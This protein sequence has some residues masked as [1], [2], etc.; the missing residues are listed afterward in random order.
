MN[1][2]W[3]S[4]ALGNMLWL[5]LAFAC[6]AIFQEAFFLKMPS[7]SADVDAHLALGISIFACALTCDILLSKEEDISLFT[8]ITFFCMLV[9]VVLVL[10][11]QLAQSVT[12]PPIPVMSTLIVFVIAKTISRFFSSDWSYPKFLCTKVM[13]V[14]D[15]KSSKLI[16]AQIDQSRGRFSLESLFSV[17]ER[18]HE[19]TRAEELYT[20]SSEMGT[21]KLYL[22]AQKV[23]IQTI[24]V[25][26]A[27]RRGYMPVQQML[28]CRML[29]INIVEAQTFYEYISRKLYIE[30]LK[31]S[32]FIF[33]SVFSLSLTRRII[34][35]TVDIIG[36]VTGLLLLSPLFP[37]LA[38][39][40]HL[41]SPGPVFFRQV[42]VGL[43][44][45]LFHIIKFRSMRN[46]AEKGT[47]AVWAKESDPRVTRIGAFLRKS[48]LDEIPQLINVL[49]GDMSLV[50][51]RP[52]RPEFIGELKKSIPFYGERHS[53]KPGVTGWAQV[54]YPYGA[55]VEDA[56][57][58][59][60]YD[61]YYIKNQSVL[62]EFEILLRTLLIIFTR[63]GAR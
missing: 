13:I 11:S 8:F 32:D 57:E 40:I 26:F 37:I 48:R 63:N 33:A 56:L 36:S 3:V 45:R 27:E 34:K 50:G 46:D 29:G 23:G 10:M 39:I 49:Q 18:T 15:S 9:S 38:L 59:L 35:R 14:G 4:R 61:L 5:G 22:E 1:T 24:I 7:A 54:R 47:G 41:D 53:V 20:D 25:S 12:L 51:P 52:E 58:K 21:D 62:L 19:R 6:T 31:P 42:R 44:D 28:K 55:S 16:H 2:T 43:H 17:N 60:R 30:N